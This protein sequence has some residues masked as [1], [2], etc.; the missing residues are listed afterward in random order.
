MAGVQ[1]WEYLTLEA[2][3]DGRGLFADRL[4]ELGA[5]GWE[6]VGFGNVID[7]RHVD[8]R[9]PVLILKRPLDRS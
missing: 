8:V 3:T 5:N 1:R 7:E 6:A 2:M 4:N 9:Y